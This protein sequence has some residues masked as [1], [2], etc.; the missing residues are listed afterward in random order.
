MVLGMSLSYM[1]IIGV[2]L[3][4]VLFAV[5]LITGFTMSSYADYI[6]PKKQIESGIAINDIQCRDDR[7]LV[8]RTNGNVA[9]VSERTAERT[10]WDL[11]QNESI[12][13]VKNERSENTI[14]YNK[15]R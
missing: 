2:V 3:A 9:C 10:G 6:S 4:S 7:V 11:Q 13:P 5:I 14:V 15:S 8:L 1:I 12:K